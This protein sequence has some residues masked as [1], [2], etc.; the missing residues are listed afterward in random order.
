MSLN[1]PSAS[2]PGN[3][4][5]NPPKYY[6]L[7]NNKKSEIEIVEHYIDDNTY[8]ISETQFSKYC[9]H[10][11]DSRIIKISNGYI[12]SN[13][14]FN[15]MKE[16]N[17]VNFDTRVIFRSYTDSF[18]DLGND[19]N[20]YVTPQLI[21]YIIEN[22]NPN[23]EL[24]KIV[25]DKGNNI[26]VYNGKKLVG[27]T[28]EEF[29]I[30]HNIIKENNG[31]LKN[32]IIR[33]KKEKTESTKLPKIYHIRIVK[34]LML[35]GKEDEFYIPKNILIDMYGL[36]EDEE[37]YIDLQADM[38]RNIET[39]DVDTVYCK[40]D[41]NTYLDIKNKYNGNFKLGNDILT[42]EYSIKIKENVNKTIK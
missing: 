27:L 33:I 10:K 19:Y 37:E 16:E 22:L 7:D 32:E 30:L 14:L 41:K 9:H 23:S 2:A 34:D 39:F 42:S 4:P 5:E 40:V 25:L 21:E 15:A 24:K 26:K 8:K 13:G 11:T 6:T 36:Y 1:P 29:T 38:Y 18:H 17:K 31:I 28:H 35:T 12:I 20:F 3:P